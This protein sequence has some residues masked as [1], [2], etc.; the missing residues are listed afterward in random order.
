MLNHVVLVGKLKE[1]AESRIVI[2]STRNYKNDNGEYETDIIPC[3]IKGTISQQVNEC[4]KVNDV[5]GIKGR[6]ETH[7]NDIIIIADKVTFL[8]STKPDE[9]KSCDDTIVCKEEE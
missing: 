1:I 8:N 9:N 5:I 3:E 7:D 6:L 4:C 2:I